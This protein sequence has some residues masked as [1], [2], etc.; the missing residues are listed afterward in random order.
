MKDRI[1]MN[2]FVED[3]PVTWI[4]RSIVGIV[5]IAVY[6]FG[7]KIANPFMRSLCESFIQ[8]W[9]TGPKY[10]MKHIL[11]FSLTNALFCFGTMLVFVKLNIF[12]LPSLKRNIKS[13]LIKGGIAGLIITALTVLQAFLTK[14]Q[15]YFNLDFWSITGNIFS[16]AYEEIIYRGLIFTG[17]LYC[18][19]N[20]WAA[21]LASGVIFG[22]SH[23][24]YDLFTRFGVGVCGM[25]LG[26]LYYNT[27]NLLAPWT[28]H[29][30]TDTIVDTILEM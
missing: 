10:F 22:W 6:L 14:S 30:V 5:C 16:N 19:R 11:F 13:S 20:P 7:L 17:I 27:G 9:E 24:Q 28:M 1:K 21:I 12:Q 25:V 23:H 26:Y 2:W 18:F 4:K 8:G 29:Q 3:K 15:F